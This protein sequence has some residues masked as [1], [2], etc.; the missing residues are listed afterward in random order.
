MTL[1]EPQRANAIGNSTVHCDQ[2]LTKTLRRSALEA[3][4]MKGPTNTG[5][6]PEDFSWVDRQ[7]TPLVQDPAE[8]EPEVGTL[9]WHEW[10]L[11]PW[12][13]YSLARLKASKW[14]PE[15][16]KHFDQVNVE[17]NE[18]KSA[19]YHRFRCKNEYVHYLPMQY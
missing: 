11:F 19:F 9:A 12:L 7:D 1:L 17:Y 2:A 8:D 16:Y 13:N 14:N 5:K 4:V 6:P 3:E 15:I 18:K 10:D